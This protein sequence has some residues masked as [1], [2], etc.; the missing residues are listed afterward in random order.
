MP[1]NFR[2]KKN[3][4]EEVP[5]N[6][7]AVSTAPA[8]KEFKQRSLAYKIFFPLIF[9]FRFLRRIPL[10]IYIIL[11]LALGIGFGALWPEAAKKLAIFG[12]LFIRMI[13][14]IVAPL[15]FATLVV[16]IA[17]HSSDLGDIGRLALKSI[18]Y[19][20]VVTTFALVVGLLMGNAL[21]PGAGMSLPEDAKKPNLSAP[22]TWEEELRKIVPT[23][24]YDAAS[25]GE[26]LQIVVCAAVFAVA[27]IKC[28]I[29]KARVVMVDFC[30][31]LSD[32]MFVVVA[33][34]MYYA[35]IGIFA[36]VASVVGTNGL[37]VLANLG[38]LVGVLY[39]T[40]IIFAVVILLPIALITRVPLKAFARAVA[41]P[42][43]I[44]FT[45]ASSEAAL[46]RAMEN[47]ER[48]GVPKRIVS[49]VLPTGYSFNLDGTTLYLSLACLFCAQAGGMHL[50]AGK[51]I[52]IVFTLML[53]SK[54]VAAVPRASLVV[55]TSA[56]SQYGL[57]MEAISLIV[58]V[59]AFMD[60]AR[61][62]I[63]VLGN[64]LAAVVMARWEGE[65]PAKPPVTEEGDPIDE[66]TGFIARNSH[67][68]KA[69]E[70]GE[71]VVT[72]TSHLEHRASQDQIRPAAAAH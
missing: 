33:L 64:C 37:G 23:S 41:Q 22:I 20:E 28:K 72:T 70:A 5:T 66:E 10:S 31:S 25:R 3:A 35:P 19:F 30:Q 32:I 59:D 6:E 71:V 1:F 61:T 11:G 16:G 49:F 57:P 13:K 29:Q 38:K 45:T 21:K 39:L 50:S 18:I 47:L 27:I 63:N 17:A 36:S 4:S 69:L 52:Q 12:E 34:V 9:V 51:Q 48:M 42:F 68:E 67:D 24:F 40:L 44:A 65:F 7:E 55:L 56:V 62:S 54:G 60:M 14:S 2:K 8:K 15:I 53:T 43:L 46:P 26:V 58:A